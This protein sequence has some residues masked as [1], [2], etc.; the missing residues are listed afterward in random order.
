MHSKLRLFFIASILFTSCGQKPKEYKAKEKPVF[1]S[2]TT[3][4]DFKLDVFDAVI[5]KDKL[6]LLEFDSVDIQND[7][8]YPFG[9]R[10]GRVVSSSSVQINLLTNK[11]DSS[12]NM[13]KT[14]TDLKVVRDSLWA[15]QKRIGWKVYKDGEWVKKQIYPNEFH[16]KFTKSD[17][18]KYCNVIFEDSI[19]VVYSFDMGEFGHGVLFLNKLNGELRGAPIYSPVEI[20]VV[21]NVYYL[22]SEYRHMMD[23]SNLTS[24]KYPDSL[25]LLDYEKLD[26]NSWNYT[27]FSDLCQNRIDN[28]EIYLKSIGNLVLMVPPEPETFGQKELNEYQ[29]KLEESERWYNSIPEASINDNLYNIFSF[30]SYD[31]SE[32]YP[33]PTFKHKNQVHHVFYDYTDSISQIYTQT[34]LNGLLD[35]TQKHFDMVDVPNNLNDIHFK[36]KSIVGLTNNT[37]VIVSNEH[38]KRYTFKK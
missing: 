35:T 22:K 14:I 37:I 20:N 30:D 13:P 34:S 27:L 2:D 17:Y 38:I 4:F 7:F 21:D 26:F 16:Q 1:K 28:F 5:Y 25:H 31:D 6:I 19:Y 18:H 3:H 15:F 8:K 29:K 12:I 23:L 33:G 11:I 9:K 24:L 36:D 32:I 10:L